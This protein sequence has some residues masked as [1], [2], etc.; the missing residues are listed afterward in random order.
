MNA[1]IQVHDVTLRLVRKKRRASMKLT[2]VRASTIAG[3]GKGLFLLEDAVPGDLIA[4]YS[5]K[6]LTA[7]KT[8]TKIDKQYIVQVNKNVFVDA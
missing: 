8:V 4:R 5:G 7:E 2:E 6:V 3:G 1:I